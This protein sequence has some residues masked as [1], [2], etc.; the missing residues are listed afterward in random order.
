MT[1][2][3]AGLGLRGDLPPAGYGELAARAEQAGLDVLSVFGDLGFQP[4]LP[5]LVLAAQTTSRLRLGP[6]CLNPYTT[7]PVEI[8][9]Q[10]AF[11]DQL[12]SGRAYL[13]LAAGAWLDQ[14]RISQPRPVA[15][16][17]DAAAIVQ[18]LLAGD[19]GGYEGAVFAIAP[20]LRLRFVTRRAEV[21]LLIGA[22]GPRLTALAGEIAAELKV[23]GSASPDVARLARARLG[24]AG[25]RAGVVMGAVTVID[26][27]GGRA[28][29]RARAEAAMYISVVAPRD[30]GAELEP[31]LVRRLAGRVAAGD[32]EG[33]GAL[34]PDQ[35]LSRFVFAGTPDEVAA[36][37]L[38][39]FDAG[40]RRVDF[41]QPLSVDGVGR[42]LELLAARVLPQLR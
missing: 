23:G 31:D 16:L 42:G 20:G 25:A 24:G 30:P 34:I 38:S 21:P 29:R 12:S 27:D 26:E 39:L 33:A 6:A 36:Q 2:G 17:R 40:A 15:A 19:D 35:V 41:G 18:R 9:G 3:E 13:G 28:R 37:A 1:R 7:H 8:A 32:H 22:W 10:T 14:A 4:P 11:L 5:A